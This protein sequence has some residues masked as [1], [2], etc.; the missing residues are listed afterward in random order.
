MLKELYSHT[1]FN[2]Y[3]Y[4]FL[5]VCIISLIAHLLRKVINTKVHDLKRRHHLRKLTTYASFFLIIAACIEI[6]TTKLP[7]FTT[8]LSF[9]SAGLVLALHESVLCFAGWILI[10][11]KKPYE[12]G[13]RIEVNQIKGDV[14]DI[15]IFHT[16]MIE[17]GNWVDADQSTGRIV[18][19]PNSSIFRH[20]VYNY[21]K[22]FRY[23][24]NEISVTITFESNW[25]K[26]REL[27]LSVAQENADETQAT[28]KELIEKMSHHYMVHYSK[29]TPVVYTKIEDSGVKLTLRYLTD[30]KKRRTSEDIIYRRIL[31]LF[32]ENTDINLAY[33]TQRFYTANEKNN[34]FPK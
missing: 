32:G 10:L 4:T 9:T 20:P 26:A 15:G 1:H 11:V 28:V 8:I 14:I 30:A 6:W 25:K 17:V 27:V 3:L 22:E 33:P 18:N 24:W 19:M 5:A 34:V 12:V 23:I 31:D 16:V 7:S 13:E 2:N 21:T 29:L